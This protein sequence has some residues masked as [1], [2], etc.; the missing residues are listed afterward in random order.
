MQASASK[1]FQL[2]VQLQLSGT[3]ENDEYET[4]SFQGSNA[5]ILVSGKK[6]AP[7]NGEQKVKKK[8]LSS[9]RRK[10]LEKKEVKRVK[11]ADR[12]KIIAEL[13][14][15][16]LSGDERKKLVSIIGPNKKMKFKG[17]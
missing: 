17:D 6:S 15:L 1:R 13:K 14:T 5:L 9:S 4:A 3:S 16:Q 7:E 2:M 10:K 11:E 12:E 8:Q